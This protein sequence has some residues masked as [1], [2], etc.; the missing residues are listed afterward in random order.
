MRKSFLKIAALTFPIL[1]WA[2]ACSQPHAP[3]D[4]GDSST[5]GEVSGSSSSG[6]KPTAPSD[7]S[8]PS[9]PL[10]KPSA[11]PPALPPPVSVEAILDA[12]HKAYSDFTKASLSEVQTCWKGSG[13]ENQLDYSKGV[14]FFNDFLKFVYCVDP[15]L[16]DQ[17]KLAKFYNDTAHEHLKN[18][19]L[20]QLA[21]AVGHLLS[22]NRFIKERIL[23][24][25]EIYQIPV[26]DLSPALAYPDPLFIRLAN[27]KSD[28]FYPVWGLIAPKDALFPSDTDQ[29]PYDL[30][31]ESVTLTFKNTDGSVDLFSFQ[32][33]LTPKGVTFPLVG[34]VYA[35]ESGQGGFGE[36]DTDSVRFE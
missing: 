32:N 11:T 4:L 35:F 10:T 6:E 8:E 31:L 18:G 17:L 36:L 29:A 27:A 12:D 15:A 28:F 9:T 21:T 25:A 24:A 19:E 20:P 13:H 1:F 5:G 33:F 7:S 14:L 30:L 23:K 34:I 2:V 26:Q 22:T 3:L 16:Q